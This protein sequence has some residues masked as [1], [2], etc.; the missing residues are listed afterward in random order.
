MCV[1]GNEVVNK[2]SP[3]D[4]DFLIQIGKE[5]EKLDKIPK[6]EDSVSIRLPDTFIKQ[7]Q[8]GG[9]NFSHL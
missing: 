1:L 8:N 2:K 6:D 3:F 4:K 9:Q 5:E 7:K